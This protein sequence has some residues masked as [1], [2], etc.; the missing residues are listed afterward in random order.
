MYNFHFALEWTHLENL[1]KQMVG[2]P[3]K[4]TVENGLIIEAT[5]APA[6]KGLRGFLCTARLS[7]SEHQHLPPGPDGIHQVHVSFGI[8]DVNC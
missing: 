3:T 8:S 4:Q 7:V 6:L 2:K 1:L 5:L